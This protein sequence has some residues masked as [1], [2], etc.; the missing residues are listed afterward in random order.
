MWRSKKE[1]IIVG[2]QIQRTIHREIKAIARR[3]DRSVG[4]I[5]RL[6]LIEYLGRAKANCSPTAERR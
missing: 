3:D 5:C 4:Q 2:F 6:A 1:W